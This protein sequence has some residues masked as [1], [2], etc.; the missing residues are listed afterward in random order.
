MLVRE[1]P[2]HACRARGQSPP[3]DGTNMTGTL[4]QEQVQRTHDRRRRPV[5]PHYKWVAL[6]NTTMGSLMAT[7]DASIVLI[8]S[9]PPIILQMPL[10]WHASLWASI[11]L[12]PSHPPI[13]R[14]CSARRFSRT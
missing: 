14:Y 3:L 4:T 13:R 12:I 8:P 11:V 9:H 1:M 5:G 10:P 6:T 2:F 7:I